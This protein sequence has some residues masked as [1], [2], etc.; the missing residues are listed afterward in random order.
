MFSG[1]PKGEEVQ[2]GSQELSD[3]WGSYQ[4]LRSIAKSKDEI[5]SFAGKKEVI[6]D[7]SVETIF[8]FMEY[9]NDEGKYQERLMEIR[10]KK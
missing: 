4:L 6:T 8:T 3:K 5:E 7:H 9:N 2:A 1:E 10:S